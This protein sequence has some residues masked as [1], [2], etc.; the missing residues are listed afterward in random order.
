MKKSIICFCCLV[1]VF[2]CK[3]EFPQSVTI[4]ANPEL[5]LSLGSP[6]T[7]D[8]NLAKYISPDEIRKMMSE[9]GVSGINIYEYR[10][11]DVHEDV[12]AYLVHYPILEMQLD[13]S[14]YVDLVLEADDVKTTFNIPNQVSSIT[15]PQF[16]I[17]FPAG[18]FL[19]GEE[20]PKKTDAGIT[21]LFRVPLDDMVNLVKEIKGNEFGL[22]ISTSG[23]LAALE[24]N[25]KV[26]IPA[27][28]IG[29]EVLGAKTYV[30]GVIKTIPKGERLVFD[31][32]KTTIYPAADFGGKDLDIFVRLDGPFSGDITIEL[33]FDWTT[34][35]I[36]TSGV[37]DLDGTYTIENSLKDFL[38][39]GFEFSD[40][41]GYIYVDG[42]GGAAPQLNLSANALPLVTNGSLTNKSRP[43]FTDPFAGAIPVHSLGSSPA[44]IDL[45]TVLNS[46]AA[47]MDLNYQIKIPEW[48]IKRDELSD[49]ATITA[50]LVVLL[51]LE[52][53]IT[54]PVS[55][56][57]YNNYVKLD[58]DEVFDISGDGDIFGRSGDDD[59]IFRFI[60]NVTIILRKL[61]LSVIK[62]AD[63]SRLIILVSD[64]DGIPIDT[65]DF[66]D[67]EPSITIPSSVISK[68]PFSPRFEVLLEKDLGETFGTFR[69]SRPEPGKEAVFDFDIAVA[70]K[71]RIDETIEF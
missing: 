6:F 30:G 68:I 16:D 24:E 71:V 35:K 28:G 22:A 46:G 8:K 40:I 33:I 13:L 25:V 60:E 39:T 19:D 14:D 54:T 65:L 42:I 4:K 47:S 61:N 55:N 53:K 48:E 15:K 63:R 41:K 11:P 49:G 44:F 1:F 36:N 18:C 64:Q 17:V 57:A 32:A 43:V 12:L 58:F 27:L 66:G 2:S 31:S 56:P 38:G 7:D 5:F 70:A 34:A 52:L 37:G 45:D 69:I 23:A 67:T 51:P 59:D 62:E 26:C 20:G 3:L 29:A 50:D 10:G 9:N 21:P